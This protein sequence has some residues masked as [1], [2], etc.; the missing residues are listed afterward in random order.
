MME[1]K[2]QRNEAKLYR[3]LHRAIVA[4]VGSAVLRERA[5]DAIERILVEI[6]EARRA[7]CG[8]VCGKEVCTLLNVSRKTVRTWIEKGLLCP[9]GKPGMR[10]LYRKF[11]VVQ[12]LERRNA[13]A[14]WKRCREEARREAG[15]GKK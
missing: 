8:W 6:G 7:D 2:K 4:G 14:V 12:L 15:W 1:A 10:P 13:G 5:L 11:E 3:A 9:R